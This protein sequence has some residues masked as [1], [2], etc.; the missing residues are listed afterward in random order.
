VCWIGQKQ[1]DEGYWLKEKGEWWHSC[2]S[3][4]PYFESHFAQPQQ[5]TQF[6]IVTGK[7]GY[8]FHFKVKLINLRT[9][10]TLTQ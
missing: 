3:G 10:G 6:Q 9:Y 2:P 1:S 5:A 4:S 7:R 8:C